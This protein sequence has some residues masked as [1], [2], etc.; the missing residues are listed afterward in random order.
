MQRESP[1]ASRDR[2]PN[3]IFA[4]IALFAW[5]RTRFGRFEVADHSMAP[6][7]APGDYLLTRLIRNG[8]V[9]GRG[10]IVV[11]RS[12]PRYLVKRVIGLPGETVSVEAGILMIDG[13]PREDPWWSAATRPDGRWPVPQDSFFVFGDNR[14]DSAHDSRSTGPITRAKIH[15]VAVARYWP[16]RGVRRLP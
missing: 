12:G 7:L 14:S 5:F 15:S 4:S 6:L 8:R 16:L 3:A 11:F 2:R 13:A 9:P 1:T 10:D